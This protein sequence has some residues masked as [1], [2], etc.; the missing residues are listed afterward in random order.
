MLERHYRRTEVEQ[1]TS[2]ARSTIY[3]MMD[4]G[5]FPRPVRLTNKT[6]AWPESVLKKWLEG[7]E[8]A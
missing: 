5:D 7:R 6:V 3:E 2:L 4:R 8:A 1:I